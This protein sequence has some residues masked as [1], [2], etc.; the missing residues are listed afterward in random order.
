MLSSRLSQRTSMA[1][2]PR[3]V[4]TRTIVR[5]WRRPAHRPR[6]AVTTAARVPTG[7]GGRVALSRGDPPD[8]GGAPVGGGAGRAAGGWGRPRGRALSTN[9]VRPFAGSP[10]G[11]QSDGENGQLGAPLHAQRA[12]Q[13]ADVVLHR[14]LAQVQPGADLPVAQTLTD[15]LEDGPLLRREPGEQSGQVGLGA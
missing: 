3:V 9:T 1:N 14:L 15:Q 13:P 10:T 12:Q 6:S 11:P 5:P 4:P 7:S 2:L 8:P